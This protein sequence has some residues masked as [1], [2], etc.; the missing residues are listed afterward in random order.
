MS[1]KKVALIYGGQSS[2]HEISLLSAANVYRAL[3]G[4]QVEAIYISRTGSWHLPDRPAFTA[5]D[6][7]SP[8]VTIR[9][10]EKDPFSSEKGPVCVEV[11]LPILHGPNGEDGSLQGLMQLL[12]L[13]CA[14]ADVA[15]SAINMDKEIMKRLLKEAGI[16]TAPFQVFRSP[17]EAL[18][19]DP[20]LYPLFVKP[21]RAGS[22]VGV[23]KVTVREEYAPAVQRAFAEDSKIIVEEGLSGREVECAVLG[24][25]EPAASTVG[26]IRLK[27]GFYDYET[28]Y[29]KTDGAELDIPARLT[30]E[31]R[32][33]VQKISLQAYRALLCSGMG[34]VDSFLLPDGRVFINEINT[35]PG[36][37]NISM[38]PALWKASGLP[39]EELLG[40]LMDLAL[41]KRQPV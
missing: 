24:N 21:A 6:A 2:E 40:Q 10:G 35:L 18:A 17:P 39:V 28:K 12:G 11:V 20:Q 38:Y 31:E 13:P 27:S 3:S 5:E 16:P 33:A 22:S 1:P 25:A 41:E 30:D 14:G 32:M 19:L 36:F 37:T 7:S 29:I 8:Q 26:E 34:R 9:P 23:S 4:H 15:G